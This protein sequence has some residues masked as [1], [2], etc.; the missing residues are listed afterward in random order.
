MGGKMGLLDRLLGRGKKAAGD[1]AGDAELRR[2]GAHQ[3]AEGAAKERAAAAEQTAQEE[4]E[5][6]A[7]HHAERE[8]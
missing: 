8:T 2:E 5:R 4:R 1:L 3:E 7:E 6:A